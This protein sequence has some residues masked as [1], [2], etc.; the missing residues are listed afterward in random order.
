[1]RKTFIRSIFTLGIAAAATSTANAQLGHSKEYIEPP[2]WSIG[3]TAGL[4]DLWSDVGTK[5][6][7]DHYGNSKYWGKPHFMGGLFVRYSAH[8]AFA[9]R[10]GANYGTLYAN[11]DWN[12]QK[13]RTAAST[14]EDA[15]QRYLR[16][17]Q[18]R[19]NIWETSLLF[20]I[21]PR[22]INYES[23]SARKR[24]QPYLLV[25]VGYFH[26]KP[27]A[28]YIDKEGND[29]GYVNLHDLNLEANGLPN[30]VY[31]DSKAKYNLWQLAVPAGIGVRWDI[32]RRLALGVEWLY[33]LTFT[34][35]LDNVS[36]KYVDPM[37]YAGIHAN[38]PGK[39]ALAAEM[40]D[41]S[42]QVDKSVSHAAG[43]NRG[44]A[45]NKDSYS[46]FGLTLIFKVP[47]KKTPW[48]Y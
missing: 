17:Q 28:K 18:V 7:I 43:E 36:G 5:S 4:A 8:P 21:T 37:L 29:R 38:D 30:E 46:T 15:Y 22:R 14:N 31:S 13:A 16:N 47:S 11:D 6:I 1:M 44:N 10:L 3:T 35:Y 41:R 23:L 45:S 19:S 48:W 9:I 25:G 12:E 39:A 20:E 33:R 42:W 26:F 2:G 27:T 34:D 40:Q 24:F 32:G